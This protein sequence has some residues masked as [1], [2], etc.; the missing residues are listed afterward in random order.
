M[1]WHVVREHGL[2]LL[3]APARSVIAPTSIDDFLAAIRA[4]MREMPG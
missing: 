1:N 3:G 2:A 4:H